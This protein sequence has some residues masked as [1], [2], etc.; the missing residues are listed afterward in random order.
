MKV[1]E[2]PC[3]YC[4]NYL[5]WIRV[6]QPDAVLVDRPWCGKHDEVCQPH[7]RGCIKEG[8]NQ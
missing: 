1:Y 8:V 7:K 2:S 4:K 6:H 5:G 3:N